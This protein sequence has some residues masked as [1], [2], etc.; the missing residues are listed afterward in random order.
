M[1]TTSL[2]TIINEAIQLLQLGD[3]ISHGFEFSELAAGFRVVIDA[4]GAIAAA[5]GALAEYKALDA[6][7]RATVD[8]DIATQCVGFQDANFGN[9]IQ[10]VLTAVISIGSIIA[11][12]QK[13]AKVA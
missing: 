2:V 11:M 12:F 8:A 10:A 9:T 6:A 3:Q 5:S 4:P 13:K 7:A 1:D